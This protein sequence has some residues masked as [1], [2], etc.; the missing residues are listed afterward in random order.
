MQAT[1]PR[2]GAVHVY[3]SSLFWNASWDSIPYRFPS[4]LVDY[5]DLQTREI[6]SPTTV[7]GP[8]IFTSTAI[9]S[10]PVSSPS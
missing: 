1:S 8:A 5:V 9:S 2:M 10:P 3:R 4:H 6:P 7:S